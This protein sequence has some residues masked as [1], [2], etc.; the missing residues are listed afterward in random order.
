MF[1][2]CLAAAA[3]AWQYAGA[4]SE[5]AVQKWEISKVSAEVRKD[6]TEEEAWQKAKEHAES[7]WELVAVDRSANGHAVYYFKRPK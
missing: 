7:G 5:K 3:G 1:V 2:L 6:A 4:Q